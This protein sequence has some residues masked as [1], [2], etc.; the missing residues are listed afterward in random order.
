MS[1][2]MMLTFLK[3]CTQEERLGFRVVTQCAPVLKGIKASNLI[4]VMP[5]TWHQIRKHLS[6]SRVICVLL[7]ADAEREVLFLYRYEMLEQQLGRPDVR[8]FLI[9]YGYRTF[10]IGDVLELLGKRYQ[11]YKGARAEFPHELGVLLEYPVADVEG[12][13]LNQ[14]RNSLLSK[15]W[16][17][18]HDQEYAERV[19]QMYDEAKETAL[20][21]I[22]KGY[23]LERVAV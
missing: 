2:E 3:N 4:T 17:V 12:F 10:A 16:K 20:K 13:I 9:R 19:F 22:V 8:R 14:G 23:S 15:Y 11:R 18:Y 21:E 5:G 7:Y 1:A 6:K